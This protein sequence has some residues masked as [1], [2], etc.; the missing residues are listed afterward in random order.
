MG[1]QCCLSLR[2]CAHWTPSV[3]AT[4]AAVTERPDAS[5]AQP[6]DGA[7][8]RYNVSAGVPLGPAAGSYEV[9]CSSE[10]NHS[11]HGGTGAALCVG[12]SHT[13]Q[14]VRGAEGL[15][16]PASR[17]APAPLP[18]A[19]SCSPSTW[20][21]AATHT[22]APCRP[23]GTQLVSFGGPSI[24]QAATAARLRCHRLLCV[25]QPSCM[26]RVT[27]GRPRAQHAA[28]T[29][30]PAAGPVPSTQHAPHHAADSLVALQRKSN[31][32]LAPS[33]ASQRSASE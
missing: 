18:L 33:Q 21:R 31:S 28:R 4:L 14:A 20:G 19:H 22:A 8:L 24:C 10:S 5:R 30:S 3:S 26:H 2:R 6:V 1:Y 32:V 25:R 7:S 12:S 15:S 17:A 27:S 11:R 16:T 23:R 9:P 13:L 29:T